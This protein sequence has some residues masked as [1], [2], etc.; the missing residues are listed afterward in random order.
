MERARFEA[1]D[2]GFGGDVGKRAIAVVVIENVA[3]ELGNEEIGE[4]VVVVI[5]PNAAEAVVCAGDAGG[6]GDVGEGPVAI[7]AI[8]GVFDL[9]AAVVAVAAVDEID[10]L[11]AVVVEIGD[12]NAGTEFLEIDGDPWLPLK[13]ANLIPAGAVTSTN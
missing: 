11:P 2:A 5:A 6:V 3:S 13:C 12:A 9:D 4:T 8:E 1:A 10:V 7:V